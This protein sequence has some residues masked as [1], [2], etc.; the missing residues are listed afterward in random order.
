MPKAVI[1]R[2]NSVIYF[3]G[4]TADKIF[5][6]Q[7][8][9]IVMTSADI[10][11]GKEIREIIQ[12]GEFFGV[13]S[14]LGRYPREES[15][16]VIQDASVL[17]F[18]VPE[19]EAFAGSN[20]RIIIKMLKVFS[21]QLRRVHKQVENLMEKPIAGGSENGLFHTGEYYL[22][23]RMYS[24]ARYIFGRYLTYYPTGK[25]A[26]QATKYLQAAEAAFARHGD[27]KG[28]APIAGPAFKDDP[29]GASAPPPP[30]NAAVRTPEAQPLSDVAKE[31]YNG[32]SLFS[33]EKFADALNAFKR[34]IVSDDPEYTGKAQ[35]DAGRCLFALGQWDG[36]I[37]HF[38]GI[39]QT[40]PKHPDMADI[41]FMMGSAW[42]KKGDAQRAKGFFGKVLSMSADDDSSARIK[43]KKAL[44]AL[45]G[46]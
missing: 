16:A 1:Y 36:S 7:Q 40:T 17:A 18:S 11:T 42:E 23:N 38:T 10:E 20:T 46:A 27:G 13:K 30:P 6:L 8:G 2:A 43:A 45:G 24:Q 29:A 12:M 22:R 26:D 28:P 34:I 32:V 35:F 39:V 9:R 3:Q 33:Q 37:K 5:V 25:L 21:N 4:D 44:N 14:A 41:L 15:V 19:F 31:Y